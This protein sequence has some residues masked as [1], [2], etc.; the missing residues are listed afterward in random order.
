MSR[1]V[2]RQTKAAGT[3]V[4]PTQGSRRQAVL[5][6]ALSEFSERGY[7]GA[8]MRDIAARAG[9]APGHLAYYARSKEGLW[10]AVVEGFASGLLG[11]LRPRRRPRAGAV[12]RAGAAATGKAT[13]PDEARALLRPVLEHFA[14]N[15]RLT[16]LMLHEFSVAS[17]RNDWVVKHMGRPVWSA[18]KPVFEGLHRSGRVRGPDPA[19]AYFTFVGGAI[20]LF[21]SQPEIRRI[22]GRGRSGRAGNAALVEHLLDN[23]LGPPAKARRRR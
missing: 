8:S 19:M 3:R 6:A 12:V 15:P 2:E 14:A 7:E 13:D 1:F 17:P 9:L 5:D 11:A 20:L 18:L 22:V 21:G 16:R 4:P 10:R 23:A